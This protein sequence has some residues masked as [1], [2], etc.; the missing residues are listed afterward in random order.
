M[1]TMY[2]ANLIC[3]V[4]QEH[5]IKK[6][7]WNDDENLIPCSEEGCNGFM[8]EEFNDDPPLENFNIGGKFKKGRPKKEQ[9]ERS[10][11][12]FHKNTYPTLAKQDKAYF[13]RKH[14]FKD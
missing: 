9:R 6:Y 4:N 12:D 13:K 5:R 11:K 8:Q 14:G 10:L 3:S 1:A 2:K 7:I